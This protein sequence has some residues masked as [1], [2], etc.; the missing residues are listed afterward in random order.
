V[1]APA[2]PQKN[3]N[4]AAGLRS[5]YKGL[6]PYEPEDADYFFGRE[7]ETRLIVASIHASPLTLLYGA[8]GVGKS[9][10]LRAGVVPEL[11]LKRRGAVVVT[12]NTWQVAPSRELRRAVREAS[13][14]VASTL[15]GDPGVEAR[16]TLASAVPDG[17]LT[18][19]LQASSDVL[20]SRIVLILDQFEE[21]FLY[22]PGDD[23]FDVELAEAIAISGF[24]VSVLLSLR[25]DSLA[26][27]DR[28][29]GRIPRL[30]D[31]FLRLEH[32]DQ[33]AGSIAITKP[34]ER[35]NERRGANA[36][37]V[38][39]GPDLVDVVLDQVRIGRVAIGGTGRG[40]AAAQDSKFRVETPYLQLV[41]NRLWD[42]DVRKAPAVDSSL[43]LLRADTLLERLGGAERIV[44]EHLDGALDALGPNERRIAAAA[45]RFLVT[46]SGSKI[47]HTI[48][49]LASYTG[50]SV[51]DLRSVL[52]SLTS[53]DERVLREV[54]P[55]PD[56]PDEPRYEI[57]HDVLAPAVLDWRTRYELREAKRLAEEARLQAAREAE[58][59]RKRTAAETAKQ[60]ELLQ[61][62]VAEHSR[63][64]RRRTV[65]AFSMTVLFIVAMVGFVRAA[66]Q[67]RHAE[68]AKVREM[69][70]RK[71]ADSVRLVA[72]N[73][74]KLADLRSANL[75]LIA[76]EPDSAQRMRLL[77]QLSDD[78]VARLSVGDSLR[79]R[80]EQARR[81]SQAIARPSLSGLAR[82]RV[83]QEFGLKLWANGSTLRVRFLGGTP[84]VRR[85]I[86]QYAEEWT[87]YAHL[88]FDFSNAPD[89]EIRIGIDEDGT[90]WSF[91]GPD[92]L[93]PAAGNET[94]HYG[95]FTTSI[96]DEEFRGVVLHEFGH[97]LGLIHENNSP[98]ARI[99]WDTAAVYQTLSGPPNYWP[100][101]V[102]ATNILQRDSGITYRAFDPQ[103][104]MMLP[105]PKA[106]TRGGVEFRQTDSLSDGD[107]V[108]IAKLYPPR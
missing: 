24:P 57:F 65:L 107:K 90:S 97:A 54:A 79:A 68:K 49:D 48:P 3:V 44:R 67:Q 75:R 19:V 85:K 99:P 55:P 105:V 87:R 17:T 11:Q 41:M 39:V 2:L 23:A 29:E 5:P 59:E 28:F 69:A 51:N 46:P 61:R 30:F 50:V 74:K 95:T 56:T 102:I 22:H 4:S 10:V 86:Q 88:G 45:L 43:L 47:A 32:L 58:D 72:D 81:D 82:A 6:L 37:E 70:A 26:A 1:T 35:Y 60:Q 34:L 18:E 38:N 27:L 9:S 16:A 8:S 94:M 83:P 76:F 14:Q 40:I 66:S 80:R 77:S 71:V 31:N 106:L 12:F 25:E 92:A 62:Q 20:G 100:R 78:S 98:N 64:A 101:Q 7:R 53:G 91:I 96:R 73:M 103:S 104:I 63:A 93:G 84:E 13:Q 21:Y 89:A 42:E 36:P 33:A 108:F 15:E 52:R